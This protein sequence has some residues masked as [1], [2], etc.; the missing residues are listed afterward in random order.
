MNTN[1]IQIEEGD[2]VQW[3]GGG[4]PS[5]KH[6]V[7]ISQYGPFYLDMGVG[8]YLGVSYGNYQTWLDL[9]NQ[10]IGRMIENYENKKNVLGAEVCL[11][12]ELSNQF[13]HHMKIWIRSS[14]FAE[15]VW[16]TEQFNPKPDVLGRVAAHQQLMNRRGI[17]TSGATSQQ[18]E[19]HP[20]FC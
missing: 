17:P 6:E 11:W 12:S 8:N 19:T 2:V 3:W 15:R 10:D 18:C 13:M 20:E 4:M 1:D 7:V 9:Y 14:A 5:T 16:T